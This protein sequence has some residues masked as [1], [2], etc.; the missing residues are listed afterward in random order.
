MDTNCNTDA[1]EKIDDA[2]PEEQMHSSEDTEG[3]DEAAQ[4]FLTMFTHSSEGNQANN[5]NDGV[6]LTSTFVAP[7]AKTIKESEFKYH[8]F[9]SFTIPSHIQSIEKYAFNFC[10]NLKSI[11]IPDSVTSIGEYAFNQCPLT[12]IV[13]SKNMT[14]LSDGVFCGNKLV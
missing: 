4:L 10:T 8:T 2:T 5:A 14:S 12:S 6:D 11:V 3:D 7:E 9:D 1:T 13:I